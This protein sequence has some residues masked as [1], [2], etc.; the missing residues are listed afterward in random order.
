MP[1]PGQ[2]VLKNQFGDIVFRFIDIL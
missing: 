2:G 1:L